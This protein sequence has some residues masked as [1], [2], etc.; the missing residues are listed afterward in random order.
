[1]SQD[2][3]LFLRRGDNR[4][5]PPQILLVRYPAKIIIFSSATVHKGRREQKVLY[6]GIIISLSMIFNDIY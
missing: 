5:Q 6:L 3:K 1:M 2:P 4:L